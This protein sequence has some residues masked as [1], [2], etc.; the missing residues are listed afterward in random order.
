ME[1]VSNNSSID[2]AVEEIT[3][4]I[5]EAFNR[6]LD[7]II[8]IEN[9][10]IDSIAQKFSSVIEKARIVVSKLRSRGRDEEASRVST[11]ILEYLYN[12]IRSKYIMVRSEADKHQTRERE[13]PKVSI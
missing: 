6:F 3:R 8:Y 2:E 11:K 1:E 7:C 4:D 10:S 12:T 9:C 5:T 13:R